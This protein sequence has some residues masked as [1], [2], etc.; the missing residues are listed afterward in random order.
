MGITLGCEFVPGGA[1]S[2]DKLQEGPERFDEP[3]AEGVDDPRDSRR[4]PGGADVPVVEDQGAVVEDPAV[5]EDHPGVEDPGA[6]Q[7]Q[8]HGTAAI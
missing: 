6:Q 8:E 3:E 1:R 2:Q 4:G 7:D 5:V